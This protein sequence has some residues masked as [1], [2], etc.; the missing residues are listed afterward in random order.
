VTLI[1]RLKQPDVANLSDEAAADL[2]NKP[3]PNLPVR[4]VNI[5]TSNARAILLT[6]GEWAKIVLVAE[7]LGIPAE[8]P[9]EIA[10]QLR[11]LCIIV[12]DTLT[13]TE[14]IE[15]CKPERFAVIA[16]VISQLV[17]AE[18]ISPETEV[19]LMALPKVHMSY[20]EHSNIKVDSREVSLARGAKP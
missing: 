17:G 19:A 3:D 6:T 15:T 2:L 10:L 8:L 5:A 11:S 7:G 1:E 4:M 9:P 12:R 14:T 13:L 20:A 18:I 16:Q